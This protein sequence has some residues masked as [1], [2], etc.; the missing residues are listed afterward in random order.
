MP[1]PFPLLLILVG[2]A[3]T[4]TACGP[5]TAELPPDTVAQVGPR[6]IAV[7]EFAR[8]L[9]RRGVTA[10]TDDEAALRRREV[11][12]GMID[13]EALVQRAYAEGLDRDPEIQRR[14]RSLL[15]H[16][17]RERSLGSGNPPAPSQDELREWHASRAAEFTEPAQVRGSLFSVRIPRGATPEMR[18]IA[19]DRLESIRQATEGSTNPAETFAESAR[20]F[21]DDPTTRRQRGDTGWIVQGRMTRWPEEVTATLFALPTPGSLSPVIEAS[22]AL[23]LARLADRK[24]ARNQTLDE[25]RPA[26]ER[27][28]SAAL[29]ARKEEDFLE[30][31]R[32]AVEIRENPRLIATVAVPA[33][34][35]HRDRHPKAPPTLPDRPPA[36]TSTHP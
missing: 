29:Q 26:V 33:S 7:D 11:L 18:R 13:E 34:S 16:E 30:K 5:R 9:Q 14:F 1:R 17:L 10:R 32:R 25:V 27:Q 21:S 15:V 23:Y 20:N 35:T 28:V 8:E 4:H 3:V 2:L 24:A 6:R 36:L 19:L 31:A 22:D 12:S